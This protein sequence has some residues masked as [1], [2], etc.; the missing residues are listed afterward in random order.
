MKKIIL[1]TGASSGMGKDFA[2]QL[3]KEGHTVYGAARRI[4]KM[5]D[6][7]A[8][9]GHTIAMDITNEE[10]V[11]TCVDKIK[12]E[13]GRIDVLIN[14][15]GFGLY[16]AVED[17]TMEEARY[18]FDV[19]LF[20]LAGLTQ[21]VIPHMR[22]RHSGT[23]INISSMG[24][25]MYTPLGAWYHATKHALEGWSDALRLELQQFGINVVIVEPGAITTEWGGIMSKPMLERS[26]GG[27]YENMAKQIA[28][29]TDEM[30]EKGEGSPV[31]VITDLVSKAVNST[32]PKTRYAGGKYAKPMM[33]IRKYLGDRIFDK[34]VM[35]Q[36]K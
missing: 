23:I 33:W 14:N 29:R 15:A 10:N 6:I 16:G 25:K 22:K 5:D 7:A 1:V 35:S 3:V 11:Q 21:K 20:G 8:A 13:Q 24:G 2:L 30:Y 31:S 19:N 27:A 4:E 32:R 34:A 12:S 28:D 18:Q 26:I 9:G 17:V 36:I